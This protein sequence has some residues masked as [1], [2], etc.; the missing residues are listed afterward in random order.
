MVCVSVRAQ[1]DTTLARL[2]E[3]RSLR[4]ATDATRRTNPA[5]RWEQYG[6]NLLEVAAYY[7]A[8][9]EKDA[10]VMQEG[11]SQWAVGG[12]V[13]SYWQLGSKNVVWGGASYQQ[14]GRKEVEWNSSSDFRTVYPYVLADTLGGDMDGERYTFYGGCATRLGDWTVG[15]ELSFRAEHE[16]RTYDPRPRGIV[17]DLTARLGASCDWHDYRWA[18]G[19]GLHFYKQTNDVDFYRE[20]GVVPEYQMTGLGDDYERFKGNNTSAYYKALGW[21]ACV[22][23]MPADGNGAWFSGKIALTPY[24]RMLTTLNALPLSK[25]N[26]WNYSASAGW[27]APSGRWYAWA[28]MALERRLGNELIAGSSSSTEYKER[29]YLTMY[30]NHLLRTYAVGGWNL[31]DWELRAEAG[32]QDYQAT[33]EFPTREMTFSK[34]YGRL[35]VQWHKELKERTLLTLRGNASLWHNV[36]DAVQMPYALMDEARAKMVQQCVLMVQNSYLTAGGGLRLD[37]LPRWK[38]SF[39]I[40]FDI[41]GG[42][43]G[44]DETSG[45]EVH[46]SAGLFF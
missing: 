46:T 15:E 13:D 29:G 10:F 36:D 25:L 32:W 44:N 24:K 27:M 30:R 45:Y 18:V 8:R 21:E 39:G 19:A 5:L 26:V 31:S 42:Y 14:G 41:D 7:D 33:Y 1:T 11:K 17:T 40:F 35:D 3:H 43:R 2:S 23:V 38:A 37:W 28:G 9:G 6:S 12:K 20:A 4:A 34:V 22:T 16:W